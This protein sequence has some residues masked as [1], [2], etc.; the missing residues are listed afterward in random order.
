MAD[1]PLYAASSPVVKIDGT[2][3]ADLARDLLRL[4]VD[5]TTDGLRTLALHVI[6]S[7]SR[8]QPTTDVVE[9]LDGQVLDF[10]KR[11]E[12]SVGPPG[13][14]KVVFNGLISAIEVS[15]EEGDVPHV[16]AR[17]EDDLMK[18]RMTQRSA[19][20][21]DMSDGDVAREIA[22][23]HGLTPSIAADGPTYDVIQQV[24]QSD[25]AFLRERARRIEAEV[26]ALDGTLHFATRDQRTGTAVTLTRGN[27]LL[28]VSARADLAHQCSSVNVS[29]F[30]ASTREQIE[31]SAPSSTVQAETSGGTTGPQTLSRAFGDLPGRRVRDVPFVQTEATA[32]AKAEMLRRSRR[33]VT[34]A[35]TT[36]GTPEL[37]VGSKVTL[38]RCG[39]AF[40]GAGYYVTRVHHGFDLARGLRTNFAAERPVVNAT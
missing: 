13:N 16:T 12:V 1:A 40:D 37:V 33:F 17:A 14:E 25:L 27:E 3:Q 29:G 8:D 11:V 10:G 35:A 36:N 15:F 28:S 31:V 38:A 20:Y 30:D 39:K 9:Y 23:K 4:D 26:W 6:A 18:L 21:T 34:I 2:R 32:F 22:G 5:E 19:T 7:A 24:N